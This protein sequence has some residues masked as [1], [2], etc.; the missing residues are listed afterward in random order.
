MK[1]VHYAGRS[2]FMH[3]DTADALIDYAR[4][5][6]EH[7]TADAVT[8]PAMSADG[9]SVTAT[10]LLNEATALVVESVP[11]EVTM[12]PDRASIEE[13]QRRRLRVEGVRGGAPDD[14]WPL[15]L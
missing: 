9:H 10:L 15:E 8:V 2:L 12:E 6:S 13:I 14:P 7:R 5:L 3:D 4:I 11:G 1:Y